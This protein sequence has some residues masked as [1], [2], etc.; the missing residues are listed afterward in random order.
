MWI[1]S[2]NSTFSSVV[3]EFSNWNVGQSTFVGVGNSVLVVSALVFVFPFINCCRARNRLRLTQ[4][5]PAT[6]N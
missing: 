1:P 5:Q 4:R 6:T 3:I 2:E